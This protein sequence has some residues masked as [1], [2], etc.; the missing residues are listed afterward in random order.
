MKVYHSDGRMIL[1][2]PLAD[3]RT[4]KIEIKPVDHKCLALIVEEDKNCL[5]HHWYGHLNFISLGMLNQKKIVHGLPQVKEP[6]QLYEKCCK[7]KH[8][9]KEF[10]HDLPVR[11]KDKLEV[12]HFDVCEPFKVMS[13]GGN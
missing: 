4:L 9:R 7:A 10:K 12:V 13:N 3:N 5:W 6:S 11:S 8:T 1:K 2:A